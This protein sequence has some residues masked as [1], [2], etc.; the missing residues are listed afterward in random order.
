MYCKK[1]TNIAD[2]NKLFVK[3]IDHFILFSYYTL[4]SY[5]Y[6]YIYI[7]MQGFATRPTNV[8]G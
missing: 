5:M 3:N 7:Y 1:N 8:E 6:I 2:E 4:S